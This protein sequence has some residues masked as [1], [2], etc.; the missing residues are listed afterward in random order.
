MN[1]QKTP[2]TSPLR[3]SY[4]AYVLSLLEGISQ[5]I[6]SALYADLCKPCTPL[7]CI[8]QF[9]AQCFSP[10]LRSV[11]CISYVTNHRPS[12]FAGNKLKITIFVIP[13]LAA[14]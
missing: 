6:E 9:S 13:M 2:H 1:L 5:D 4:G 10:V 3:A 11:D 7:D 12:F 8:L 14:I